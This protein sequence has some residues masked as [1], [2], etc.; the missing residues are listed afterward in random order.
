LVPLIEE[1]CWKPGPGH[2]GTSCYGGV[3]DTRPSQQTESSMFAYLY[4]TPMYTHMAKIC[5]I[6]IHHVHIKLNEFLL[7]SQTLTQ[8]HMVHSNFFSL[9][10]L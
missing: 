6:S 1:W 4:N 5:S 8:Y 7:I 10:C 9:S 2:W 3:I